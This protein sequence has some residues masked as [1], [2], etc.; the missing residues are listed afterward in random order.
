MPQKVQKP[1]TPKNPRAE[2]RVQVASCFAQQKVTA[3][4]ASRE[5]DS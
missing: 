1:V 3:N 2:I 5:P 4:H